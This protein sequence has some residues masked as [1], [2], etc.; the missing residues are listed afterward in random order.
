MFL[1]F[2]SNDHSGAVGFRLS[3][4]CAGT[5]V[6][7][8]K[9]ADVAVPLVIG[10]VSAPVSQASTKTECL[11]GVLMS[12]QCCAD[13]SMS[14]ANARVTGVDLSGT[15]LRGS[16]PEAMGSLGALRSLRLHDN[17]LTGI[18]P[19][20][21]GELH[22]LREL[23]LSHNQFE[24]Q[25]RDSLSAI[26]GGLMHLRTARKAEFD[27]V[28]SVDGED[29]VPLRTLI[30]PT[31]GTESMV[32]TY[33]RLGVIVPPIE[34]TQAHS[35]ANAEG[36]QCICHTG[37]FHNA[38]DGGWSC[39]Q[40]VRGQEPI[41][42]GTRCQSCGFGEFSAVGQRCDYCPP[43]REPNEDSGAD[44]CELCTETS[45]S[46]PGQ[47]CEQCPAGLI[48]D[49]SRTRC[50]CPPGTY[51]S[52]VFD[53]H[54]MQCIGKQHHGS[55][56]NV[57]STTMCSPCAGLPC[58]ECGVDGLVITPGY[59]RSSIDAR[60]TSAPWFAFKCPGGEQACVHDGERRSQEGH[61][62]LLCNV[63]LDG[64]GMVNDASCEACNGVNSSPVYFLMAALSLMT[65]AGL[66][67]YFCCLRTP[68]NI[69][70]SSVLQIQLTDN[71]LQPN[72]SPQEGRLSRSGTTAQRS[73]DAVML[74]RVV[75]QPG[76][77]Y[78]C[79]YLQVITQMGTCTLA[80]PVDKSC[81]PACI[82]LEILSSCVP[83]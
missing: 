73:E 57:L 70:D 58:I 39:D 65:G 37:Y 67:Y 45:T 20:A 48:A 32:E 63:C 4:S 8:W 12:V 36:A 78:T 56:D 64:F 35:Y 55:L 41:E 62:G 9:P 74:A 49:G 10:S 23:Q 50:I 13:A 83:F 30:D 24:M 19:I 2:T 61:T 16:I 34:C 82:W 80:H 53:K 59:S 18:L 44:A 22:L 46:T 7:Y 60:V 6:E 26:I 21:L 81:R 17:F 40:C 43:G 11:S 38:I 47:K 42:Q 29:F 79:D 14:C 71:P 31:T 51:N 33:G 66:V 68:T 77:T 52:T 1:Q 28:L 75:Y 76:R 72:S 69:D 5:L 15:S 54:V 3:F 27:F 25:D